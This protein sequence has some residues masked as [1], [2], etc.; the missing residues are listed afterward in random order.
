MKIKE[1]KNAI[2][3]KKPSGVTQEQNGSGRGKGQ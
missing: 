3:N 1:L 2:T